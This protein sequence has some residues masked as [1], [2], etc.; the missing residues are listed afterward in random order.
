MLST[1]TNFDHRQA[2]L[3]MNEGEEVKLTLAPVTLRPPL[4]DSLVVIANIVQQPSSQTE[5][6]WN[7][8]LSSADFSP[9]VHTIPISEHYTL[10]PGQGNGNTRPIQ[11]TGPGYELTYSVS[12]PKPTTN[13][14][15]AP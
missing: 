14:A 6:S 10:L 12:Y 7:T 3:T 5:S 9:G 1:Y 4:L 8:W 11:G 2:D 13:R 15:S